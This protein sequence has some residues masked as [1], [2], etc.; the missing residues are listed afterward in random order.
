[1][2]MKGD[3]YLK[4]QNI[5]FLFIFTAIISSCSFR[6]SSRILQYPKSFNIDTLKT[7][8]VL[9][10][11]PSYSEYKIKP[12]DKISIKNL[13]D[14]TLLGSRDVAVGTLQ[15]N[16]K[17][18][19]NGEITLPVIG[20]V[21]VAG[22]NKEDA[23]NKIEKLY[24]EQLFKDPIIELTINSLKV[25]LLGAFNLEGNFELENE[26]TDLIEMIGKAG[27]ISDE[28]NIKKIRII[29]GNREN[30]ELIVADL[31]NINTLRSPK[32]ILQDGDIII[33]ER[34]KFSVI[35]KN[36]NGI[37]SIASVATLIL[38]S[39]IIIKSIN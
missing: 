17:V 15:I 30:P 36:L 32:L 22:L 23:K 31:S 34:N 20:D 5:L 12:Y 21:M 25:T 35:T 14:P 28:T 27:G 2:R 37:I 9:N 7:V 24:T 39:Y 19:S 8:A 26:K 13:Q 38:N 33:A 4:K 18:N 1:M 29:R 6:N 16:Y 10:N 11:Q 3:I